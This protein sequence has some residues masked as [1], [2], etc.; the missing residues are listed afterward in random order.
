MGGEGWL[1]GSCEGRC[2]KEYEV[3]EREVEG[4]AGEGGVRQRCGLLGALMEFWYVV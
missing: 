3:G 2:A 1:E 4:E